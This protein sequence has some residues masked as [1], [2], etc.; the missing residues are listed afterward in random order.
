ML[1]VLL[2]QETIGRNNIRNY[3]LACCGRPYDRHVVDQEFAGLVAA[4]H[5]PYATQPSGFVSGQYIH[6]AR[7]YFS[8]AVVDILAQLYVASFPETW[9]LSDKVL[10]RVKFVQF[11]GAQLEERYSMLD[12]RISFDYLSAIKFLTLYPNGNILLQLNHGIAEVTPMGRREKG[13]K[14]VSSLEQA[15]RGGNY[16]TI[17]RVIFHAVNSGFDF[18]ARD[19][20]G[21]TVF[22]LAAQRSLMP[23]VISC[24]G[25]GSPSTF[26]PL[27]LIFSLIKD[28]G[29][30]PKIDSLS[31]D[32]AS[33][34][35]YAIVGMSFYDARFLLNAN[36]SPGAYVRENHNPI[37][38][39]DIVIRKLMEI[40]LAFVKIRD[41]LDYLLN[42]VAPEIFIVLGEDFQNVESRLAEVERKICILDKRIRSA[43][44]LGAQMKARL[45]G[46]SRSVGFPDIA[47]EHPLVGRRISEA[48]LK[49][50][51]YSTICADEQD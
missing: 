29:G 11:L 2:A 25:K 40:K 16:E 4:I 33:A 38:Q 1:E 49:K 32:G 50:R 13:I 41:P 30:D 21:K 10:D 5:Q 15:L 12:S 35:Y 31:R 20:S 18:S 8:A 7:E 14:M 48:L 17:D 9:C 28:Y 39:L 26:T 36:V 43:E 46:R 24:P 44:E 22:H 42:Y 51:A 3:V 6:S 27:T 19:A 23:L 45:D 34:L 37:S 47:P